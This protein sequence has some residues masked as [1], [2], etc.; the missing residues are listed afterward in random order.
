MANPF[1]FFVY[2][3]ESYTL[4]PKVSGFPDHYLMRKMD[5]EV[6]MRDE[7]PHH[8]KRLQEHSRVRG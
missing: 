8:T 4:K 3:F 6:S 7:S 1:N 5:E 2:K